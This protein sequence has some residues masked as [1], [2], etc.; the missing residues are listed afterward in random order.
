MTAV[1][2]QTGMLSVARRWR[3]R[4]HGCNKQWKKK[5]NTKPAVVKS[6]G[7]AS[8]I[9]KVVIFCWFWPKTTNEAEAA[10]HKKW[11]ANMKT[12]HGNTAA[13]SSTFD[14]RVPGGHFQVLVSSFIKYSIETLRRGADTVLKHHKGR[15]NSCDINICTQRHIHF[16][17]SSSDSKAELAHLETSWYPPIRP[18]LQASVVPKWGSKCQF[19]D[20]LT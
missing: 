7:K 20:I 9:R 12:A 8:L 11:K 15:I 1:K 13:V 5:L 4:L 6:S 17:W 2:P 3:Y 14:Q 10:D 18:H 16:G 19:N